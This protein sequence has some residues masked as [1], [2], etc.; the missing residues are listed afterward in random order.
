EARQ[1]HHRHQ[2]HH[3]AERSP[4]AVARAPEAAWS[5][6]DLDLPDGVAL[7]RGDDRNEAVQLA[8][9]AHLVEHPAAVGL[10]AAVEIVE[11]DP[12]NAADGCVEEMRRH[13]AGA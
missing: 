3:A 7:P 13:H 4:P 2:I 9:D 6:L 11:L 8:V 12:R 5:V 10:E 1:E